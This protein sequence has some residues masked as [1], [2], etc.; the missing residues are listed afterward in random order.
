[1]LNGKQRRY[2]RGLGHE[3]KPI[4]QIGKGG[5]D[6]GLV[7]AVDQALSD[8]ELIKL[9]IG[10]NANVDRHEAAA[11]IAARTSS[12][13]AQVLGNTVLLFRADADDPKITLP[14][15]KA[16]AADDASDASDAGDTD[17]S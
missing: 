9:R 4:V 7:A 3:L 5:V 17:E 8:H 13:V 10:E 14:K 1:V 6:D 16:G 11:A 15:V 12:H 2:L